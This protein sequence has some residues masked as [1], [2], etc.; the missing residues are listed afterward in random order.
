MKLSNAGLMCV[1]SLLLLAVL[2]PL[3]LLVSFMIKWVDGDPVLFWQIRTGIDGHLFYMPKFRTMISGADSLKSGLQALNERK[4]GKA[5]KMR[6][7]PRVTAIGGFLRR[8]SMDELPQL[9]NVL[10][11]DM[12]LVGPRPPIPG[13]VVFYSDQELKRLSVKPGL[14][15]LWQIGGRADLSFSH[16]VQMDLEYIAKRSILLDLKILLKTIPAV[17]WG[18]GA[19]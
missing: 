15:G 3:L 12:S 16:Q 9:W 6:N 2:S 14:T 11:G 10:K 13:E 5:F 19:Y 18:K 8:F 1:I 7:D 17:F 4:D